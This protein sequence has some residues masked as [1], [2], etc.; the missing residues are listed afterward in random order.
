MRLRK[1][2]TKVA[3][4]QMIK[5]TIYKDGKIDETC[6]VLK[7]E[8][9]GL[10]DVCFY[11]NSKSMYPDDEVIESW[12]EKMYDRMDNEDEENR[13]E[14]SLCSIEDFKK[15]FGEEKLSEML[16]IAKETREW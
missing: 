15:E 13:I 14:K 2:M 9:N 11:V 16:E 1:K 8:K 5:F 3:S 4:T 6:Y 10:D 7:G 12:T